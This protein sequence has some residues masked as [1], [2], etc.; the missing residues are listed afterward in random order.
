MQSMPGMH[1]MPKAHAVSGMSIYNLNGRWMT[2]DGVAEPLSSLHGKLV[3][4]AMIFT[5]CRDV[6]PL[7]AERMQEV[8]RKLPARK[9]ESVRFVL[10]S[11]DWTRDTPEQLRRFAS[12]HGLDRNNWTLFHG[13]ESAVRALAAALGVSFYRA[14]N[15]DYQHS[16]A[17]FV[18][19]RE[20][21][22]RS[23]Q[24]DLE[25]PQLHL[26]AA[27]TSLLAHH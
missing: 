2:Q 8:E 7:I 14:A 5:H 1:E 13:N 10:F 25:K 27:L 23:E 21:V 3:V 12:Q 26:L 24:G 16:I 9:R 11:L 20:G 6:C 4:A 17:I 22:M 18:L 15:G 19:D